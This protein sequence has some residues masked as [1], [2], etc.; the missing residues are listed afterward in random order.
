M[1]RVEELN[2]GYERLQVLFD[3]QMKVF[4][5]KVTILVGPNGSGKS[6]LL[7]AILGLTKVYSGKILL[8]NLDIT[9]IPPHQKA[10]MGIA[11]LPQVENIF[12]NLTVEENLKM[13]GYILDES[14]YLDGLEM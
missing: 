5:R 7:K 3:V 11:Y 8:D 6:T 13:A 4:D 10:K 2:A 1:L 9:F 12:A 14:S